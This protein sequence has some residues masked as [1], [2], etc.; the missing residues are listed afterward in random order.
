MF[1][2]SSLIKIYC[3]PYLSLCINCF[4]SQYYTLAFLNSFESTLVFWVHISYNRFGLARGA[5]FMFI[6]IILVVQTPV[7][8]QLSS[9]ALS[10][11]FYF[12]KR[13]ILYVINTYDSSQL[14]RVFPKF[15]PV[16]T[17]F[18]HYKSRVFLR[19]MFTWKTCEFWASFAAGWKLSKDTLLIFS[20]VE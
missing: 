17:W 3:R 14:G 13:W 4:I 18:I 9:K 20:D 11:W 16:F 8:I 12:L 2:S 6:F 15:P 7:N 19:L 1:P 10:I 5:I